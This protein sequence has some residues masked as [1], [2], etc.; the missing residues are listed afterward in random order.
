MQGLFGRFG[1]KTSPPPTDSSENLRQ[2]RQRSR[3]D[4][5]DRSTATRRDWES[6]TPEERD[7]P[8]SSFNTD[9]EETNWDDAEIDSNENNPIVPRF[10]RQVAYAQ[11]IAPV[12]PTP[13][14]FTTSD[15]D[16]WDEAL[17]AAT[18]KNSTIQEARRSKN[19]PPVS[20]GEDIWDDDTDTPSESSVAPSGNLN[21]D[22][23][24][25]DRGDKKSASNSLRSFWTGLLA[26]FRQLLPPP[27]RQFSNAILTAIVVA[28]VTIGIWFVDGFFVPTIAPSVA[29]TPT[30]P[31]ATPTATSPALAPAIPAT[32]PIDP[33]R[34]FVEAIQHQL[35]EI[36]SQYPDRI[37]KSIGVDLTRDRLI[38]QLETLWYTIDE[39]QQNSLT[40]RMWL[41]AQANHFTKLEI[42]DSQGISIARS[43]VV[44]KHLIILQRR[45]S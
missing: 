15:L 8:I 40:D 38:V 36:T 2:Q 25:P 13:K 45:Q 31:I 24:P 39:Q 30:V 1:K 19:A 5:D 35:T 18:V 22:P 6:S 9:D 29:K 44:G 14:R 23:T 41:Q 37:V 27:I 21:I 26:K 4:M 7:F 43:P 12:A 33:D 32:P 34:A 10:D 42:Q 20:L 28:I 16:D 3:S 17:P 11:P